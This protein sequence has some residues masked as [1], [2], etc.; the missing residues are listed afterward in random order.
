MSGT[1]FEITHPLLSWL[2]IV[3]TWRESYG[4]VV[5]VM[6]WFEWVPNKRWPPL[7]GCGAPMRRDA[8]LLR[9]GAFPLYLTLTHGTLLEMLDMWHPYCYTCL[10]FSHQVVC[11]PSLGSAPLMYKTK[12]SLLCQASWSLGRNVCCVIAIVL[13]FELE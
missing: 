1:C 2:I 12:H 11:P 10:T 13:S 9:G 7:R 3:G 8:Y 5:G 6:T 4:W